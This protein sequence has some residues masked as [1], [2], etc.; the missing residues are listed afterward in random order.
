MNYSKRLILFPG[1]FLSALFSLAQSISEEAF[2][3]YINRVFYTV[4]PEC[5]QR[6]DQACIFH[7]ADSLIQV[8]MELEDWP[9]VIYFSDWKAHYSDRFNRKDLYYQSLRDAETFLINY[10]DSLGALFHEYWVTNQLRWGK[11]YYDRGDWSRALEKYEQTNAYLLRRSDKTDEDISSIANAFTSMGVIHR[12]QGA[13][14]I[15]QAYFLKSIDFEKQ[16]G[17]SSANSGFI[18]IAYKHLGDLYF[19]KEDHGRA[20]DYYS[21]ARQIYERT[22]TTQPFLRN[23]LGTTLVGMAIT[24]KAIGNF[25]AAIES[26]RAAQKVDAGTKGVDYNLWFHLGELYAAQ[27]EIAQAHTYFNRAFD[28]RVE[29]FGLKHYKVAEVYSAYGELAARQG[30]YPCALE[31]YQAALISLLDDFSDPD[32]RQNPLRFQ[33][34]FIKK[35][36][37][38]VFSR[39][40]D[41]LRQ[42]AAVTGDTA[43]LHTA[44]AT[45][46]AAVHALDILKSGDAQSEEDKLLF[47]RESA[48]IFEHGLHLALA[49]GAEYYPA[50][51]ELSEKSKAIVLLEA[52]RSASALRLAGIPDSLLERESQLKYEISSAEDALF[53]GDQSQELRDRLLS[54]QN[55]YRTL[56]RTLEQEY[57]AYYRLR[58]DNTVITAREAQRRLRRGQAMA[59]YFTG[60]NARFV[61]VLHPDSMAMHLLPSDEALDPLVRDMRAGIYDYF[62]AEQR[63]AAAYQAS[64][65]KYVESARKLYDMLLAPLALTLPEDLLIIPDGVLGYL[66]FEAL[67]TADPAA[68]TRFKTHSYLL[69]RHRVSY[70]Y[71]ATLWREMQQNAARSRQLAAFAPAF[72]NEFSDK[73]LALRGAL[74]TLYFNR[75]EVEEIAR[76]L[77][78]NSTF[79]G[80]QAA[81][82][83][84]VRH[85]PAAGILHIASHGI[86][87][88]TASGYSFIAFTP[89]SADPDSNRLY[90]RE[91]Y[92]M[93]LNAALVVLSA[94]E[95]GV[96]ELKKG[97]GVISLARAFA[98]AGAQSVIS[99]LWS[100]N[101]ESTTHIMRALYKDLR[102]G[103]SKSAALQNAKTGYL[104][105]REDDLAAHPF[106]WSAYI[107]VG[108]MRPLY[109]GRG[110]M[111]G[112]GVLVL[113]L[114]SVFL[115]RRKFLR[116]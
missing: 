101:D 25:A 82:A 26:F 5:E 8:G 54:A 116:K 1:L 75:T 39:K 9:A 90:A 94:C 34:T 73:A 67:L 47:F 102:A 104:Q 2:Q 96:G 83:E 16:R 99:T 20:L 18:A 66:P 21:V 12:E 72:P 50:A 19:K 111:T 70:C 109:E 7:H 42:W 40:V 81:K 58:Y 103:R 69:H 64:A 87:N 28:R 13:Y 68:A 74:D 84:F 108:D 49:L 14:D 106:Y 36:I 114:M 57:S 86:A 91:L 80:A 29:A 3:Q 46:Q 48:R 62:L 38:G 53:K 115:W 32:F 56:L 24:H 89:I 63:T 71:S 37:V 97:E 41:A 59:V 17:P 10:K 30:D 43:H 6:K 113:V 65:E 23:G 98:Y 78:Q 52:F 44:W 15:A 60:E 35:D 93:R 105:S 31:H 76:V 92:N 88:D 11:Y 22:D 107:A 112:L 51:F 61:F 27:G 95:T 77:R 55:E 4:W 33:R 79:T 110:W 100:V 85:A 45:V